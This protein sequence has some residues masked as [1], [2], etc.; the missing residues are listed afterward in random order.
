MLSLCYYEIPDLPDSIGNLKHLRYLDLTYALIKRLPDSICSLYNLQTLILYFCWKL[1]ELPKMMC[2]MISLRHLDIRHSK[3]KEIPSQMG[4]LK[5]L[6]K[7]SD[8]IVGKESGTRVGELRE[9]SQIGGSLVIQELQNVVDAKDALQANLVKKQYLD[10]LQLEWDSHGGDDQNGANTVLNNL[11]PHSNLKRLTIYRYGGS[12]F[13]NWFG[14]SSILNM[15]SLRLWDC[16]NVSG[17]P[18][19]G[20]LPSLKHL[21]IVRLRGVERVGAEFYG[22]EPSFVSLKALSFKGMSKWKEWSCLE[23]QGGEFPRLKELYIEDCPMLTGDLPTHLPLLTKLEIEDCE[24]LVAPLPR[25][26]AIRD[27]RTRSRDISRVA[28]SFCH[29]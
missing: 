8:Y 16:D 11:Q 28:E 19:L 26:P 17:F 12:R 6:Q 25:V 23:G 15:V 14:G 3:V 1:V 29:H 18:P 24:E 5:S 27:M 20:Q 4:L 22:A 10:E 21:Y 9:L 7:L 2:K 13:P